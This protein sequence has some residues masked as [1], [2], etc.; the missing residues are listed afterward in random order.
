MLMK[1]GVHV[2]QPSNHLLILC[3]VLLRHAFKEINASPAQSEGDLYVV[4]LVH[5][6]FRSR[7]KILGSMYIARRL[8]GVPVIAA[9]THREPFL[10]PSIPTLI[11]LIL[12]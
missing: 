9:P 12:F 5:K 6:L 10:Y 2:K 3:A 11:E 7:Q 4:L 8:I 1:G